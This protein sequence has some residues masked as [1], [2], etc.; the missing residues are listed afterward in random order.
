M[1]EITE[2]YYDESLKSLVYNIDEKSVSTL[3]T[4]TENPVKN[5]I[6]CVHENASADRLESALNLIKPEIKNIDNS[7]EI[8]FFNNDHRII[9]DDYVSPILGFANGLNNEF[10]ILKGS[11][12]WA[13]INMLDASKINTN[14][15]MRG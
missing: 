6:I 3:S 7:P 9:T 14:G 2:C 4:K 10:T 13:S 8:T 1:T 15:C 5:V 12:S 11:F